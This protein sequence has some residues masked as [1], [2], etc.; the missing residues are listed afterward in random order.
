M[1]EINRVIP[2]FK[3]PL[4]DSKKFKQR[5]TIVKKS[6]QLNDSFSLISLKI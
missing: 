4:N 1:I 6:Q 2:L 5:V 3:G